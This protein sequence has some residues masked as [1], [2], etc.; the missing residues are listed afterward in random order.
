MGAYDSSGKWWSTA[1]NMQEAN[2]L[3]RKRTRRTIVTAKVIEPSIEV[4]FKDI[5]GTTLINE[6]FSIAQASKLFDV[7]ANALEKVGEKSGKS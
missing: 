2:A 3:A 6:T 1:L 7:L 5:D 4:L